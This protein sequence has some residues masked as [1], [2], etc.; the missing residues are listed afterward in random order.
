[1]IMVMKQFALI[2]VAFLTLFPVTSEGAGKVRKN[3]PLYDYEVRAGWGGRP[4][5]LDYSY[6]RRYDYYCGLDLGDLYRDYT[7]NVYMTGIISAEFSMNFKKWFS[8]AFNL[9]Y[10]GFFTDSY[11]GKTD[12]KLR[13][14]NGYELI[15]MPQARFSYMSRPMVSM[16]SSIGIG[17]YG[18]SF[19]DKHDFGVAAHLTL[20]GITFGKRLFGVF[21]IGV[22]NDYNGCMAGVGYR[23]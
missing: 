4:M 3:A 22:G 11:S 2:L 21:E 16:Y 13:R 14:E 9:G 10:N 23:F 15:F 12:E 20:F 6:F 5:Y 18:L 8:L 19:M 1:M 17:V 7:G